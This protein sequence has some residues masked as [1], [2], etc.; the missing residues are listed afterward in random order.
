MTDAE[1]IVASVEHE[2]KKLRMSVP[3]F[4]KEFYSEAPY[5]LDDQS[6]IKVVDGELVAFG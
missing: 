4:V 5:K 3:E 1:F 6:T 2:A